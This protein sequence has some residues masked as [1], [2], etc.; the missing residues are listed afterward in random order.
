VARI[1]VV[2]D[3]DPVRW[4]LATLLRSNGYDVDLAADGQQALLRFAEQPTDVVLMDLHMPVMGGLE[5][6]QRLRQKSRVPI[7]ITST[8]NHPDIQ[9]QVLNSG[10]NAFLPKPMQFDDLLTW[11][12][13]LSSGSGDP[14]PPGSRQPPPRTDPSPLTSNPNPADLVS[15]SRVLFLSLP[16]WPM[17]PP[18][19]QVHHP[20]SPAAPPPG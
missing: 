4:T 10:A 5:A 6:C 15:G 16:W 19:H 3:N 17:P 11:V 1:L 12:R 2:E 8:Y 7:L 20:P 9:E 18:P 14:V 13:D